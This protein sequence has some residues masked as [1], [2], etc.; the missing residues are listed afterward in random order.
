MSRY[1]ESNE[2][3]NRP[4]APRCERSFESRR[5]FALAAPGRC[6]THGDVCSGVGRAGYIGAQRAGPAGNRTC[7]PMGRRKSAEMRAREKDRRSSVLLSL[8]GAATRRYERPSRVCAPRRRGGARREP[9]HAPGSLLALHLPRSRRA[10][11]APPHGGRAIALV[12]PTRNAWNCHCG[13]RPALYL[14][15]KHYAHLS[16][17]RRVDAVVRLRS[18]V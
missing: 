5:S 8:R 14:T 4:P 1:A 7:G 13:D 11:G 12:E 3:R 15:S 10:R 17:T 16:F 18:Y 6:P 2:F 9:A